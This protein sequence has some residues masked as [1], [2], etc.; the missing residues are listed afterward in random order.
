VAVRDLLATINAPLSPVSFLRSGPEFCVILRQFCVSSHEAAKSSDALCYVDSENIANFAYQIGSFDRRTCHPPPAFFRF[1]L[2]PSLH[3]HASQ[4]QFP[5]ISQDSAPSTCDSQTSSHEC[6][7]SL[8]WGF[9]GREQSF[10]ESACNRANQTS[11]ISNP[12]SAVNHQP[13]T[14]YF[15]ISA[16]VF[17]RAFRG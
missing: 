16:S 6:V 5:R 10:S 3:A 2:H 4:W 15:P 12:P 14:M 1:I 13:S 11:P 9:A 17:F 7:T 8:F